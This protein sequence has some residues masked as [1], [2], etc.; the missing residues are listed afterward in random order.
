MGV[1]R[2]HGRPSTSSIG[3]ATVFFVAL[4]LLLATASPERDKIGEGAGGS[5]MGR[6]HGRREGRGHDLGGEEMSGDLWVRR[7]VGPGSS[8][9]TCRSKCG[10][11]EPCRAVHVP[12]HP[13]RVSVPLEYYPEAWRCKCGNTLFMP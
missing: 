13:G 2:H 1:L 5:R 10:R 3:A 12:I 8:P 11:C 7:A 4:L 6:H 9:P